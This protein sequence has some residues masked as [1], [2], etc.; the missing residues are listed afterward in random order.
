M[1]NLPV[2]PPSRI[3]QWLG[4]IKKVTKNMEPFDIIE[5]WISEHGSAAILRD[6]LG[7]L[8]EKMESLQSRI[9]DKDAENFGLKEN[10]KKSEIEKKKLRLH[11]KESQEE[12]ERLKQQINNSQQLQDTSLRSDNDHKILKIL[13][14]QPDLPADQIAQIIGSNIEQIKYNL[15]EL[16]K[17]NFINSQI[18]PYSIFNQRNNKPITA[19][20]L[21]H[22]GRGYMIKHGLLK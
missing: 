1:A 6:H 10:F 19:W 8:K 3:N 9:S 11:L 21:T 4:N 5:K 15:E 14:K 20:N 13:A 18:M 22:N 12:N 2:N 17:A 16:R 7:L